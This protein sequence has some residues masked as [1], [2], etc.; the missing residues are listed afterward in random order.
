[1]KKIEVKK[2]RTRKK[3]VTKETREVNVVLST[4]GKGGISPRVTFPYAWFEHMGMNEIDK[5]VEITYSPRTKKITIRKK[6]SEAPI[7]NDE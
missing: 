5:K 1:M 3:E 4:G 2:N 7:D 6:S